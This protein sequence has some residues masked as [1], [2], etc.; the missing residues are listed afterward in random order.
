MATNLR[1]PYLLARAFVGL[2]AE[3]EG[4]QV[5]TTSS[6][7][8]FKTTPG[9]SGYQLSKMAVLRL[10]EFVAA[11]YKDKGVTAWCVHPGNVMTDMV[12]GFEGGLPKEAE[13]SEFCSLSNLSPTPCSRPGTVKLGM[14]SADTM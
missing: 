12:M 8:A 13:P 11:E 5:V 3:G 6:V 14:Y 1:G 4:G 7:G 10:M 9:M 2:L